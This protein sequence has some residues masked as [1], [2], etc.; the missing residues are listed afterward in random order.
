LE[1]ILLIQEKIENRDPD[2][3]KQHIKTV[4]NE[5]RRHEAASRRVTIQIK[6][7]GACGETQKDNQVQRS[8]QQVVDSRAAGIGKKIEREKH[9]AKPEGEIEAWKG[10]GKD[11]FVVQLGVHQKYIMRFQ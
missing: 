4:P 3:P 1:G 6:R 7:N 11:D 5:A 2:D 9:G 10:E 8:A